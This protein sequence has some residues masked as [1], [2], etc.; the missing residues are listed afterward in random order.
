MRLESLSAVTSVSL[1]VPTLAGAGEAPSRRHA[2]FE[3]DP[4]A[5]VLAGHSLHVGSGWKRVRLDLGAFATLVPGRPDETRSAPSSSSSTPE[6]AFARPVAAGRVE[7]QNPGH[8]RPRGGLTRG[9]QTFRGRSAVHAEPAHPGLWTGQ[10]KR[11]QDPE[12]PEAPS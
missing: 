7:E 6:Q 12:D 4:T 8:G 2:D 11:P 10:K 9:T 1:L 5:L 3:V